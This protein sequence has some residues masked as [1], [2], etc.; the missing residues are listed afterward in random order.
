[1]NAIA[2]HDTSGSSGSSDPSRSSGASC[3]SGTSRSADS[4]RPSSSSRPSGTPD[5]PT[6][7][8]LAK[9]P[10]AG[11]VKTRLTPPFTP[12]EA[13]ALAEAALRDTLDAA[14]AAPVRRRVLVLA[15]EPGPW[16]PPGFDVVPQRGD[17][18]DERIAAAFE[19]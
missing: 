3:P 6:L 2:P 4:P 14:L 19:D 1:M 5:G 10:V 15:G 16:L 18:L 9:E 7:L 11:R 17:G 8:V 13:A 12:R